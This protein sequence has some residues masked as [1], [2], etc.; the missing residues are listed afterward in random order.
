MRPDPIGQPQLPARRAGA[1]LHS[2][3]LRPAVAGRARHVPAGALGG[4]APQ[5]RGPRRGEL[6]R[7]GV[8]RARGGG[9]C[10]GSRPRR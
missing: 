1:E 6:V 9:G 2:V 7:R 3:R 5:R 8:G 10:G 4:P